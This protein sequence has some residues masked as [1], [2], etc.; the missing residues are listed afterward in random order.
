[1]PHYF[2]NVFTQLMGFASFWNDN[3]IST[4]HA[5]QDPDPEITAICTP[6]IIYQQTNLVSGDPCGAL[7]ES[8]PNRRRK[9]T[10]SGWDLEVKGVNPKTGEILSFKTGE[11]CLL[12]MYKRNQRRNPDSH[13]HCLHWVQYSGWHLLA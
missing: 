9:A 12:K 1:M 13:S 3:K 4:N 7:G 11:S 6:P 5:V 2:L 10:H 8:G